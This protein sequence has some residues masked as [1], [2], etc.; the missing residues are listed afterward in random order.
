MSSE[1]R[2]HLTFESDDTRDALFSDE[3]EVKL[4]QRECLIKARQ[5]VNVC[6]LRCKL[7]LT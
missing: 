6:N 2:N 1:D 5:K 4:T 7:L 3:L